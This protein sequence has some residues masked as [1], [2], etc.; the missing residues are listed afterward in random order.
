MGSYLSTLGN[1]GQKKWHFR[2][3][4]RIF[5]G[6]LP[7]VASLWAYCGG[8]MRLYWTILLVRDLSRTV[9]M[10]QGL[11][12]MESLLLGVWDAKKLKKCHSLV[13]YGSWKSR[14][15]SILRHARYIDQTSGA[16]DGPRPLLYISLGKW[17]YLFSQIRLN[18]DF[19]PQPGSLKD[20]GFDGPWGFRQGMNVVSILRVSFRYG[21]TNRHISK[22]GAGPGCRG[23][24]RNSQ[25]REKLGMVWPPKNL[26]LHFVFVIWIITK[27]KFA[28][29]RFHISAKAQINGSKLQDRVDF[30]LSCVWLTFLT[31]LTF[32]DFDQFSVFLL[33]GFFALDHG[34]PVHP[35]TC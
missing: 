32:W 29:K 28:P 7:C 20:L 27:N 11:S 24:S 25:R 16:D 13:F 5:T 1:L 33:A 8:I 10:N 2:P 34:S 19:K 30:I 15:L 31:F 14:Q 26:N 35:H 3:F 22:Y 21:E 4:S 9:S 6:V 18:T 17:W 23:L 12:E